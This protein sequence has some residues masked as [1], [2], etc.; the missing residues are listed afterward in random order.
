[1]MNISEKQLE[2]RK[3]LFG[4]WFWRFQFVVAWPHG[5]KAEH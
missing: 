4:P 1:M 3:D 5:A 2:V